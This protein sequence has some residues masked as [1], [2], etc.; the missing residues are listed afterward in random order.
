MLICINLFRV[1]QPGVAEPLEMHLCDG[2]L[3]SDFLVSWLQKAVYVTV[4]SFLSTFS[5][6]LCGL[7]GMKHMVFLAHSY[8]IL[9]PQT[10]PKYSRKKN[11][12]LYT[13]AAGCTVSLWNTLCFGTAWAPSTIISL[14]IVLLFLH[15]S[16]IKPNT[17]LLFIQFNSMAKCGAKKFGA[18]ECSIWNVG[19]Q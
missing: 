12:I 19:H 14:F 16:L 5:M 18:L 15:H 13:K 8:C 2:D 9:H 6:L 10:L 11:N 17:L 4:F 3:M 1:H 7:Q